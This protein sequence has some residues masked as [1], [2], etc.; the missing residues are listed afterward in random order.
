MKTNNV[1]DNGQSVNMG[2]P[3]LMVGSPKFKP[4]DASEY[5]FK[6]GSS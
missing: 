1:I 3:F 6:G 4:M 5:K 2:H